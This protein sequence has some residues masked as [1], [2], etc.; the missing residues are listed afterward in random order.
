MAYIV[1]E[2]PSPTN[3]W[4]YP[5]TVPPT[6]DPNV[7]TYGNLAWGK[8]TAN[9]STGGTTLLG[10]PLMTMTLLIPA[11][12]DIR[13]DPATGAGDVVE[14]PAG[15]GRYYTVVFVDDLG[16]DFANEHRGAILLP[17]SPRPVPLP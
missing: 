5:Q 15:T 1:P 16:K 2:M 7:Q 8:R 11:H 4:H 17:Q 10:V 12:T 6:G 13:W 9:P 3:I 14:V